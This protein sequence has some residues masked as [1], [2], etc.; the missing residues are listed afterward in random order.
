MKRLVKSVSKQVHERGGLVILVNKTNIGDACWHGIIDYQIEADCDEWV[1]KLKESMSDFFMTQ[2]QLD[3]LRQLK[4]EASELRKRQR[5]EKQKEKLNNE[6]STP[7]NSPK[8]KKTVTL[9]NGR[10]I[11]K[12]KKSESLCMLPSPEEMFNN[13]PG[14]SNSQ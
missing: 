1:V 13:S 8:K 12:L 9:P 6:P 14:F 4:R 2:T 3:K 11:P 10:P 5:E 7:P